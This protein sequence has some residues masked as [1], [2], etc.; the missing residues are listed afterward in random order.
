MAAQNYSPNATNFSVRIIK[1]SFG[2]NLSGGGVLFCI[3]YYSPDINNF[4]VR[5]INIL[6]V[7]S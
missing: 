4:N 7:M 3:I 1:I 2:I 6:H 5:K